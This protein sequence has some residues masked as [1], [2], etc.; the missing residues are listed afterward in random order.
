M[1]PSIS[2]SRS[3]STARG[4]IDKNFISLLFMGLV[5]VCGLYLGLLHREAMDKIEEISKSVAECHRGQKVDSQRITVLE[6]KTNLS[7][8]NVSKS[9][10]EIKRTLERIS[11][12]LDTK[13]DKRP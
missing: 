5:G 9:L 3:S 4:W 12:K 11:D 13:V 2:E 7:D 10:E 8:Q 6:T 1:N